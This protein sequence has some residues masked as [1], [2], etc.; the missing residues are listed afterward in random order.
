MARDL[1]LWAVAINVVLLI[2]VVWLAPI[3]MRLTAE[4][5]L[6]QAETDRIFAQIALEKQNREFGITPSRAEVAHEEP[7]PP[8]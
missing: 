3:A 8:A 2:R 7:E 4:A 6:L 1:I 5:K